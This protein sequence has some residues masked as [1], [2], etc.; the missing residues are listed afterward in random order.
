MADYGL[1]ERLAFSKAGSPVDHALTIQRLID[2]C[3]AVRPSTRAEERRGIDYVA[4]LRRSAEV[5]VDVKQRSQGCSQHWTSG[6]ELA[7]ELWSVAPSTEKPGLAGWTLSESYAT[8]MVLFCFDPSDFDGTYL[9]PF[10]PLRM[11]FRRNLADWVL[12]YRSGCQSSGRW[13]SECLFVPAS[14]VLEAVRFVTFGLPAMP[15]AYAHPLLAAG[16]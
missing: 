11:A 8:D 9:V 14:V 10:Q 7:L 15:R 12:D 16:C 2:G 3:V 1:A 6:P 4:T 5:Y 13:E